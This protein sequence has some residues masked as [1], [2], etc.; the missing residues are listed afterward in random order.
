MT[1]LPKMTVSMD[2]LRAS[3]GRS[4]TRI[5]SLLEEYEAQLPDN[6]LEEMEA[7]MRDLSQDIATLYCTYLPNH[8][9]FTNMSAQVESLP[10]FEP[11]GNE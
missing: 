6:Y 8:P 9:D 10:D 5:V 7:R 4:Y 2:G 3:A 1:E 11:Q